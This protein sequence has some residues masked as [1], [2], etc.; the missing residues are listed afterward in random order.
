AR[1]DPPRAHAARECPARPGE[2]REVKAGVRPGPES[3]PGTRAKESAPDGL[4]GGQRVAR[5]LG[6]ERGLEEHGG[7]AE[8]EERGA[9]ARDDHRARSEEHTAELESLTNL[10]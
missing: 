1:E 4:A 8:P 5:H 6:V 7:G 2:L 3:R 10:V 9:V